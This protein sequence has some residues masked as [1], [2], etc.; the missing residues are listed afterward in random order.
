MSP[1]RLWPVVNTVDVEVPVALP[2]GLPGTLVTSTVTVSVWGVWL[3]LVGAVPLKV[4][5]TD[6][7][8]GRV[9][10]TRLAQ[11]LTGVPVAEGRV[12]VTEEMTS[13]APVG[14]VMTTW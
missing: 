1:T 13:S 5:L 9:V 3:R 4:Q 11:T 2:V 14:L 7:P 8:A 10:W 6:W 12:S